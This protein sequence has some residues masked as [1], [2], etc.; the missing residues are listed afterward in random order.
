MTYLIFGGERMEIKLIK[1]NK[2][3]FIDL[4]L[5]ADEQENMIDK[6]LNRGDLFVLYDDDVRSL[7]VVT[8]EGDGI[9]ELKSL[10]TYEKYQRKGYAKNL[11][12]FICNYYSN[13]CKTLLVGTGESPIIV[14][15][16]LHC[17]FKQSHR[18]KNFFLDNYDKPIFEGGV[19]LIDMVYLKKDFY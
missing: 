6:Y 13:K 2:K 4:L 9:F 3:N 14:P 16:Y 17:G 18:V 12:D 5:L 7:C 1:N 15:F 11:I 8:E 19:Q 10:A